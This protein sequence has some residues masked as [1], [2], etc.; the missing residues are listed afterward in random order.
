VVSEGNERSSAF[1]ERGE[2]TP[3]NERWTKAGSAERK[4][5]ERTGENKKKGGTSAARE[6][7]EWS[8]NKELKPDADEGTR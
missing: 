1:G 8:E 6:G 7:R 4:K 2:S 3:G 5:R